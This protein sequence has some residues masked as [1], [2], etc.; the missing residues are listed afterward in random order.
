MPEEVV[1]RYKAGE[2]AYSISDDFDLHA[3]TITKKLHERDVEVRSA[4]RSM[5]KFGFSDEQVEIIEGE[6]LGDGCLKSKHSGY[7][8]QHGCTS[9]EHLEYLIGKLPDGLFND[10]QPYTL[11]D[12]DFYEIQS[13][14]SEKIDEL[15]SRWYN[16]RTKIVPEDFELTE[17]KLK[18]W[19]Y[20]DG[21]LSTTT[22][23]FI[24]LYTYGFD[25]QSISR[26]VSELE[27]L[28]YSPRVYSDDRR[29][30]SGSGKYISLGAEDTRMFT[31]GLQSDVTEYEYKFEVGE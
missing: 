28:G 8:Y 15:E 22:S 17:T 20:G 3:D 21:S 13:R 10:N 25:E 6:L 9:R 12:G 4:G 31:E 18:H 11:R 2:S 29:K 5:E 19:Y 24:N 26:L 1:D 7:V 14:R 27:R 23:P 16:D 30:S